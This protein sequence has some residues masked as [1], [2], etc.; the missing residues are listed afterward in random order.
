MPL[1]TIDNFFAYRGQLLSKS[2]LLNQIKFLHE[3]RGIYHQLSQQNMGSRILQKLIQ[4][5]SI[6]EIRE[7]AT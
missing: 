4:K 7:M 1:D 2:P 5:A 3:L 6:E